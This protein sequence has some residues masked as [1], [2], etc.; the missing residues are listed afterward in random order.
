MSECL[1][2]N[3]ILAKVTGTTPPDDQ[4][5]IDAH[6]KE[7]TKC[8]QH[9]EECERTFFRSTLRTTLQVIG[10]GIMVGGLPVLAFVLASA[11]TLFANVGKAYSYFPSTPVPRWATFN[12]APIPEISLIASGMFFAVAM[13]LLGWCVAAIIRPRRVMSAAML[14]LGTGTVAGLASFLA[15]IGWPMVLTLTIVPSLPDMQLLA[16]VR[17]SERSE[18]QEATPPDQ[19]DRLLEKYPDLTKVAEKDRSQRLMG[20]IVAD[21]VTGSYEGMLWGMLFPFALFGLTGFSQGFIAGALLRRG[22]SR[23]GSLLPYLEISLPTTMLICAM[24]TSFFFT[25]VAVRF[26][27]REPPEVW[28]WLLFF[29]GWIAAAIFV[30]AYRWPFWARWSFYLTL[31]IVL[32][33]LI[34]G[35]WTIP[36]EVNPFADL[37]LAGMGTLVVCGSMVWRE[38]RARRTQTE[39][40]APVAA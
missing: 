28:P 7:C 20:K 35:L 4:L 12:I 9:V 25:L 31:E 36:P 29:S 30:V 5:R 15:G 17:G 34:V 26:L 24:I 19:S 39:Q 23:L 21:Q 16:D 38:F 32:G 18:P 37:I 13:I 8:K 2:A 27:S 22:N 10:I 14:S 40:Q 6:L 11:A 33:H 1:S 3:E